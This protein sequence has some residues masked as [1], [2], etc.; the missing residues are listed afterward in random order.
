[1]I[2][3]ECMTLVSEDGAASEISFSYRLSNDFVRCC[4]LH[5]TEHLE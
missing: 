2:N 5:T 1:M 4:I 3:V